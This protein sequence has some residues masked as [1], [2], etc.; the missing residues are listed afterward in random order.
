MPS[1]SAIAAPLA[2]HRRHHVAVSPS[3]RAAAERRVEI[4]RRQRR[5]DLRQPF[6]LEVRG[7]ANGARARPSA[8]LIAD[9]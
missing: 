1:A 5:R 8:S 9:L 6:E 7:R 4:A 3:R 2:P